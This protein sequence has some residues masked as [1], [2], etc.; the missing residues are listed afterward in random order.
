METAIKIYTAATFTEQKRIRENKE[1]L[2][3]LG[4]SVTATWLEEQVKP[5]GMTDEQFRRKMA[6]KDLQEIASADCFILDLEKP[7]VTMGKMV[8]AG[9]ALAKHKLFYV[10]APEGTLT[11]GHIFLLLADRIF[12]SWEELFEHFKVAHVSKDTVMPDTK[13]YLQKVRKVK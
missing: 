13:T 1:K 4:H 3:Q 7:S 6:A 5:E 10:V 12:K 9:F 8:E 2:F 11:G